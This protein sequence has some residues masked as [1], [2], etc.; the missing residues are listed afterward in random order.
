MI[1]L[2]LPCLNEEAKSLAMLMK[3]FC[4][5]EVDL[6]KLNEIAD[7]PMPPNATS[8]DLRARM[9]WDLISKAHDAGL[10]QLA[11]PTEYGG[12]GYGENHLAQGVAAEMAGYY[13]G[14]M[15][16]LFT[17]PW[18]HACTLLYAPRPVQDEVFTDFMQ[19]RK[20]M[21][22][23]SITEPNSGSDILLPYDEPGVAG[24]YFGHKEGDEWVFN[25][26]K[27]FCTA[28]GVSNYIILNVRTEPKGPISK[29]ATS[30]LFPTKTPG[31]S[32]ARVNDMMGNEVAP[33]VQMRFENCRIPDRLRMTPINGAFEIMRSRL[34]GK[35]LHMFAVLGWA[36]ST[37]EEIRD[38]AKARIQ[39]GKPIIQHSSVGA[40]VAEADCSIKAARL[41]LYQ[42]AWE[43]MGEGELLSPKGWYYINYYIKAVLQRL[44][45]I[46][47]EVY[48]GMAPQKEMPFE[49]W[50]RVHYS[51]LHGGS[52]GIL[53]LVKVSRMIAKES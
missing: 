46:G 22:A 44:M 18:K 10:R 29:S 14:Q 26:D 37:Y 13:G 41:L 17:I 20:T 16:R 35:S 34:A 31:W 47:A 21:L 23:G 30:F 51:M 50:V 49:H 3:E 12:G 5:R 28:G 9:P 8:A 36:Q 19:D 42:N 53:S 25:G 4:E 7:K 6:K 45:Q 11:V 48:G 24:Q 32:V 39:G 52:N 40:M 2:N 43:S 27:M 33:N 38:Y 15:G 1:D